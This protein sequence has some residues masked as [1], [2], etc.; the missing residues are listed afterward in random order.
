MYRGRHHAVIKMERVSE[1][2]HL[3]ERGVKKSQHKH[4]LCSVYDSVHL[5]LRQGVPSAAGRRGW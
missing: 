1:E 3:K 4:I 2:R 5:K